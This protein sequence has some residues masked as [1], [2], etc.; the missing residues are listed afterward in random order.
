MSAVVW[1]LVLRILVLVALATSAAL[2]VDYTSANPAFC[3][4][5][6][7][8]ASVRSSGFGYVGTIPV[9]LLGLLGF[10]FLY[11]MS[12]SQSSGSERWLRPIAT[13]GGAMAVLL[14]LMQAVIIG[15][16]CF[17]CVI[18]D[19]AGIGAAIAAWMHARKLGA[20]ERGQEPLRVVSWIL[21]GAI[22][23]TAPLVWPK[24]RPKPNVP[25]AIQAFYVPGKINV[26]EFAD[27][28]C[29]FCRML[30]PQLKAI[31]RDYPGQV[32]FV[33]MNMPLDRHPE[34]KDAARAYVCATQQGKGEA[35]AD[36][37]FE[38]ETLDPTSNRRLAV[39]MAL[40]AEVYDACIKNPETDATIKKEGQILRESGFQGLPTTYVGSEMIVGAQEEAVFREAFDRAARGEGSSGVPGWAFF[41]GVAALAAVSIALGRKAA[42]DKGRGQGRSASK[43]KTA[44]DTAPDST[45]PSSDA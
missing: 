34:A 43:K 14:I 44:E 32:N 5:G 6:S 7:G 20:G 4:P 3:A 27:F 40:D 18:V 16:I 17:Y 24:V 11:A 10:G 15:H 35:M 37:L 41:G 42:A 13:A 30:H 2:L 25:A 8:C 31:T 21:L 36:A 33:R 38:T 28:Q 29:P 12:L 19:G 1:K 45:P 22:A 23:I 9:P 26:V 39:Q